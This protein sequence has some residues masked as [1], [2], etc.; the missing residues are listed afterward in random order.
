MNRLNR[1]PFRVSFIAILLFLLTTMIAGVIGNR[2]DALFVWLWTNVFVPTGEQISKELTV[3]S[4]PFIVIFILLLLSLGCAL[5]FVW[6]QNGALN[7]MSQLV[8][9]DTILL[10]CLTDLA[11]AKNQEQKKEKTKRILRIL[12]KNAMSSQAAAGHVFRASILLPDLE[13]PDYLTIWADCAMPQENIQRT[14]FYIGRED[15]NIRRGVA[16]ETFID[17]K[18]RIAHMVKKEGKWECEY[19]SYIHFE[20]RSFTPYEA[21][22][23][24]PINIVAMDRSGKHQYE[25]I[26]VVCFDSRHN[27]WIFDNAGTQKLLKS[28]GER[29]GAVISFYWKLRDDQTGQVNL[30]ETP[31]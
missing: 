4:W 8:T 10:D 18:L 23:C 5:F 1:W 24:V 15:E 21:F 22:A 28:F 6:K 27:K 2:S 20:K 26:G 7:F 9:F 11:A 12:L 3:N 30:E 14:A 17:G 13:K 19:P 31:H 25:K 29:V 16:G